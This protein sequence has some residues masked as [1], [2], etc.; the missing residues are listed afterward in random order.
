MQINIRSLGNK[1]DIVEHYLEANK[2]DVAI[3]CETWMR[4]DNIKF[5][6]YEILAK[7]RPDG[8]GGVAIVISKRLKYDIIA[9]TNYDP[10]ESIEAII[11]T[12]DKKYKFI[13][14]Y[15]RPRT[16]SS[17]LRSSFQKLID[18]NAL[19]KNLII[20]GDINCHN[21][22][23]EKD[24]ANDLKGE[25]IADII[26]N[27]NNICILNDGSHTFQNLAANYSS[28]LD[29]TIVSQNL[30]GTAVWYVDEN[31]TSDHFSLITEL[32][33]CSN[34]MTETRTRHRIDKT[35]E[36]L[37]TY[38]LDQVT[39]FD[40]L[41]YLITNTIKENTVTY[42]IKN[43]FKPK[44]WWNDHIKR[45]W[46][47][48]NQKQKLHNRYKTL[49]TAIELRKANNHLKS[50]IRS[51]KKETWERY[52][53]SIDNRNPS[54]I[55][56]GK[57]N[58][59]RNRSQPGNAIFSHNE[60]IKEFL[61]AHFMANK[62]HQVRSSRN[63]LRSIVLNDIFTDDDLKSFFTHK[64][65]KA[66]GF[67]NITCEL[68]STLPDDFITLITKVFNDI[69]K[70][71]TMPDQWKT[72]K[73]FPI[74][75][76]HKDRFQVSSYRPISLLPVLLKCFNTGIKAQVEKHVTKYNI[77]PTNTLGFTKGK[78]TQD[79]IFM[80]T[81]RIISN[82]NS[83]LRQILIS[84]DFSS[85]F[86]KVNVSKLINKLKNIK[87]EPAIINWIAQFLENRRITMESQGH[88][89]E[90]TTS[91]GL[92]QGSVLSPLLFNIYTTKFHQINS[93][94]VEL[95]QYADDFT[96]VISCPT[97]YE[98]SRLA[99]QTLDRFLAIAK[100]LELPVNETKSTI[101]NL[102]SRKSAINS[103]T[104]RGTT[105]K[106]SNIVKILGINFDS[107]LN[108][109]THHK[110]LNNNIKADV[111]LI[112][113]LSAINHGIHPKTAINVFKVIIKAK[114][115]Y[116]ALITTIAAPIN[117]GSTQVSQNAGL[118]AALGLIKTTPVCSITSLS[119][120]LPRHLQNNLITLKFI[121]K[122]IYRNRQF[123][124]NS[125]DMTYRTLID[126]H[127]LISKC[128]LVPEATSI[129][130]PNIENLKF[131]LTPTSQYNPA[132][133]KANAL[134]VIGKF[135]YSYKAYTDGSI[136]T[137]NDSRGIGIYHQATGEEFSFQIAEKISI[138]ATETIAI[139]VALNQAIASD[140]KD[141]V[142]F[143]DSRSALE[144]IKSCLQH[145][146]DRF[147]E[148]LILL[149]CKNNKDR[150]VTIA[151]I[152]AHVGIR[153]NEIADR[154][155]KRGTSVNESNIKL[156]TKIDP[157]E[158]IKI[159]KDDI[160][161]Q[162]G[163]KYIEETQT[164]GRHLA[165]IND[166]KPMK[167]PWFNGVKMSHQ[168]IKIINRLLCDHTFNGK[169][170]YLMKIKDSNKCIK[171]NEDRIEDNNHI[172][173][174]CEAYDRTQFDVLYRH[175]NS[176]DLFKE[177]LNNVELLNTICQYIK[178]NDIRV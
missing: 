112:K 166:F 108:F 73:I 80:L 141:M 168:N 165:I 98:L 153:G 177:C 39:D 167:D 68:L 163:T 172:L 87:L 138:K 176:T 54:K 85:A 117:T 92:P 77:L 93:K 151:W 123:D 127:P 174:E 119:G 146:N 81:N 104:C 44:P 76:A 71:Q 22:L 45:M 56:W 37:G 38:P 86:D 20:A 79:V 157:C 14:F 121:V 136:T 42:K 140:Q 7:N 114:L 83:G 19:T 137:E 142:I 169:L 100:L 52:L 126:N 154:L 143:T 103:L 11:Y 99:E 28:A 64:K 129:E 149:I 178:S 51:S 171:C 40:T 148:R 122:N 21:S 150:R 94:N 12:K 95:F 5:S 130:K 30:A 32:G 106:A 18:D 88:L 156:N 63:P 10:I 70:S 134:K 115:D 62:T 46:E 9:Q 158:I 144:S 55:L 67:D 25:I 124:I 155:A 107:Q 75:K 105:I 41:N 109:N 116:S 97:K 110:L 164:K 27:T 43:N 139:L 48:K 13:S 23:W 111:N 128:P 152:P 6:K 173:F 120:M 15:N 118:R 113:I 53:N 147:F 29:I 60:N 101:L 34:P 2:I 161:T 16:D 90:L 59:L 8:F 131:I 132:E 35:V 26:C 65:G 33:T 91:S 175:S 125:M 84:I 72:A 78:S 58:R 160:F 3:L 47:I 170:L 31:L 49:Y 102:Y 133:T 74:L 69:W 145:K 50:L 17:Q 4:N 36:Q 24:S 61:N 162:W 96:M 66:P 89:E 57:I 1:K 135:R 159:I 82:R